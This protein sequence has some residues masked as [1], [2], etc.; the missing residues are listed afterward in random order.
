MSRQVNHDN[1][2]KHFFRRNPLNRITFLLPGLLGVFI[3]AGCSLLESAPNDGS[4]KTEG[5]VWEVTSLNNDLSTGTTLYPYVQRGDMDNDGTEEMLTTRLFYLFDNGK[6]YTGQTL[7]LSDAGSDTTTLPQSL[8]HLLNTLYRVET[9]TA[10]TVDMKSQ[11][12]V[13]NNAVYHLVNA[14][15]PELI[16]TGRDRYDLDRDGDNEELY[17]TTMSLTH[18]PEITATRILQAPEMPVN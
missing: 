2:A 18:T 9:P 11:L 16:K 3:I 4:L 8:G 10:Y 1:F 12:P 15:S 7:E 14:E 6:V 17:D 13:T 5:V